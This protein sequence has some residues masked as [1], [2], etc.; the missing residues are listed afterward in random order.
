MLGNLLSWLVDRVALERF[1]ISRSWT[2]EPYLTRWTL[3]GRRFTGERRAMFLHRFQ[4]SDYDEMHDHPWPFTS[5]I[6]WG[7]YFEETPGTGW[8]NGV[9]PR[10]KHWYGPGRILRRPAHWIHRVIIPEGCEAWTLVLRGKKERSWGFWCPSGWR[11]W[12]E[13]LKKMEATGSGCE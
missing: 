13:H 8:K 4:R 2:A 1:E 9:G 10:E 7:G 11:H 6:L 3:L 5:V 12:Q